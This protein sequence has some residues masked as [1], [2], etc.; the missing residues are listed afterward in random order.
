MSSRD[1]GLDQ[2]E[3]GGDLLMSKGITS[4]PKKWH[5]MDL[6]PEALEV[7]K[8]V[9]RLETE[10]FGANGKRIAL[11]VYGYERGR[12]EGPSGERIKEQT[13]CLHDLG[14]IKDASNSDRAKWKVTEEGKGVLSKTRRKEVESRLEGKK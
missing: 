13:R 14:L 6:P 2:E 3:A 12:G 5:S 8:A 4:N 1:R 7:L 11:E 10:R 9:E